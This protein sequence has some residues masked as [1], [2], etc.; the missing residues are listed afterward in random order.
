VRLKHGHG[1]AGSFPHESVSGCN[2]WEYGRLDWQMGW[3][4]SDSLVRGTLGENDTRA[5]FGSDRTSVD[6]AMHEAGSSGMAC[7]GRGQRS[8]RVGE[9]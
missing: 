5:V 2:A 6:G 4:Q 1:K 9:A 7:R 8:E 3:S